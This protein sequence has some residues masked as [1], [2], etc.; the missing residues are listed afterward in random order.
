VRL[1]ETLKILTARA[2]SSLTKIRTGR[3]QNTNL[4]S[5][6][7]NGL[8]VGNSFTNLSLPKF[9]TREKINSLRNKESETQREKLE[10]EK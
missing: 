8:F 1:A 6:F 2:D 3:I 9:A 4:E 5:Y 10:G 7:Y